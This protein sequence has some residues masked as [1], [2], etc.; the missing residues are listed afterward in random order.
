MGFFG[1]RR[2]F[3]SPRS[4]PSKMA[5]SGCS[6]STSLTEE[7][8]PRVHQ[9]RSRTKRCQTNICPYRPRRWCTTFTRKYGKATCAGEIET[10][11][12]VEAVGLLGEVTH[13][14]R[15][16]PRSLG[17]A[18]TELR[19]PR[20]TL[21]RPSSSN[22]ASRTCRT[23]SD[24][25]A[26]KTLEGSA[27]VARGQRKARRKRQMKILKPADQKKKKRR[28]E[29][30]REVRIIRPAL[31]TGKRWIQVRSTATKDHRV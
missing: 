1:F 23:L 22:P 14:H 7:T 25:K 17:R 28:R 21:N 18:A 12:P 5:S 9:L 10:E 27:L 4:S 30:W 16:R 3:T 11:T 29:Q 19:S 15:L 6:S 31:V 26:L 2:F 13:V 24:R 8:P 20:L